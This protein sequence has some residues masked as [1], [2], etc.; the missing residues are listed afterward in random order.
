MKLKQYSKRKPCY[1]CGSSPPS[2]QEHAPPKLLFAAFD[3]DSI[4]VPSCERHNNGKSDKD[5]AIVTW[6][7]K[8]LNRAFDS[9]LS[10]DSFSPTVIE[11]ISHLKPNFAK[12]NR[13]LSDHSFLS[14]PELDFKIP[15][16]NFTPYAWICQ[17]SAALVWSVTGEFDASIKWSEAL[18]WNALYLQGPKTRELLDVLGLMMMNQIAES[19]IES[20]DWRLGWSAFPRKYPP[21]I[22]NF[23]ICFS[24][25]LVQKIELEVAFRHQFYS[26]INW[27]IWFTPSK[28]TREALEDAIAT[29]S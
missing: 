14:D 27:Y 25:T 5:R 21:E 15:A 20:F 3:C 29:L 24:P 4:T 28:Q 13:E 16:I 6:L 9:G 8:S 22:Y 17:L 12:A 19:N 11:A 2:S 7:I 10:T 18:V 23:S 26:C 1:Y